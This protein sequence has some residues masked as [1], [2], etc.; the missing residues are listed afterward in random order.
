MSELIIERALPVS[1]LEPVGDGW[2]LYGR[3]VPYGQPQRV[4]DDGKEY[5]LEEFE[6]GAFAKDAERGGRWVNLMVGHY[7]DEGERYLGRCVE[8]SEA[9]QGLDLAFRL[10]REHPQ[11]EEAR[12]GELTKW[13]VSAHVYRSRKVQRGS[14]TV[15]LREVCGLSHVAATAR[16]QYAG[17]G[18]SVARAEHVVIDLAPTPTLDKYRRQAREAQEAVNRVKSRLSGSV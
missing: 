17:A 14:N 1:T 6:H 15:M 10:N 12:S 9:P 2:T 16:P 7:G 4:T 13:S 18:V 5:Y 3:A 8:I 11:A